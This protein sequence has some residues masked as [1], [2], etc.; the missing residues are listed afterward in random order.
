M[1]M[2]YPWRVQFYYDKANISM[3][4][5]VSYAYKQRFGEHDETP[6]EKDD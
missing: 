6:K 5:F 1:F 2:E 4:A 3:Q